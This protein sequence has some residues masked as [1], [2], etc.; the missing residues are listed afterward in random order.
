M[1]NTNKAKG[2]KWERDI[3]NYLRER[4]YV[5]AERRHGAGAKL[6]KGDV[7]GIPNV[8][9]E[10]KDHARFAISDW[11]LQAEEERK[12]AG[13]KYGIVIAKRRGK[14]A[15][16]GY[17]IMTQ[18]TFKEMLKEISHK[19]HHHHVE[20]FKITIADWL[21]E[22]ATGAEHAGLEHCVVVITRK[23]DKSNEKYTIT[24]LET[25]ATLAED[26]APPVFHKTKKKS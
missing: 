7:V 25:F 4:G 23:G 18:K 16:A 19:I 21:I 24:T 3:V 17:V 2:S 13:N 1:A 22:A 5:Q 8:T 6:D 20:Y 10:A 14:G 11:L 26:L 9:I 15:P 12:N